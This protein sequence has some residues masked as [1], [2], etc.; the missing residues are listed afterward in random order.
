MEG[1]LLGV[2]FTEPPLVSDIRSWVQDLNGSLPNIQ[3]SRPGR[4]APAGL[5]MK[6]PRNTAVR[7]RGAVFVA[8]AVPSSS[9]SPPAEMSPDP[10]PARQARRSTFVR[11]ANRFVVQFVCQLVVRAVA[12]KSASSEASANCPASPVARRG[13]SRRGP[14]PAGSGPPGDSG[15]SAS[16]PEQERNP[17]TSRIS[18][19]ASGMATPEDERSAASTQRAASIGPRFARKPI[20]PSRTAAA[21]TSARA[22]APVSPRQS[23]P[24]PHERVRVFHIEPSKT[25]RR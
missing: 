4:P 11:F 1:L 15:A 6:T 5:R 13:H 9:V 7:P 17:S 23:P 19:S 22:Q 12:G 24:L 10:R 20:N 25:G 2:S 18:E 8:L 14:G 3:P 16:F 21:V